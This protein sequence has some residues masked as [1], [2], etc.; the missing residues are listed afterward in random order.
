MEV[1]IFRIL[2][3][4]QSLIN[5][6]KLLI[7]LTN[8]QEIVLVKMPKEHYDLPEA[9]NIEHMFIIYSLQE[10]MIL[11]KKN[12]YLTLFVL[13]TKLLIL[14]NHTVFPHFAQITLFFPILQNNGMFVTNS[15]V[16]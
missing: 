8:T 15:H 3:R 5:Q 13:T 16:T 1:N 11:K 10:R 9:R 2:A 14:T 7:T 12:P 6:Y 4:F